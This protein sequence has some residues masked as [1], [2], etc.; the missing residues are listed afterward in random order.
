MFF[1][2]LSVC[3]GSLGLSILVS[4][5]RGFGNDIYL[6]VLFCGCLILQE[7]LGKLF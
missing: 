4:I 2:F 5:L 3:E 6:F 7:E 1:F